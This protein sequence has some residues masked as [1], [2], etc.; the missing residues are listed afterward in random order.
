MKSVLSTQ[1]L[2]RL[3]EHLS[4]Y[5]TAL[6][7]YLNWV[8]ERRVACSENVP[9]FSGRSFPTC[10]T[11]GEKLTRHLINSTEDCSSGAAS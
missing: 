6:Q 10:L 11:P 2:I 1:F 9:C 5:C 4:L 8:I 3:M 7:V